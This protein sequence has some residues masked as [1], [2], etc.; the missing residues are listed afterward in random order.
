[1][2][3]APLGSH[4]LVPEKGIKMAFLGMCK[5]HQLRANF[6]SSA[7]PRRGAMGALRDPAAPRCAA[8][9]AP[10]P[11]PRCPARPDKDRITWR[12]APSRGRAAVAA[13]GAEHPGPALGVPRAGGAA[14]TRLSAG[15]P[16][17]AAAR[18][19][20]SPGDSR[21]LAA[22]G[23]GQPPSVA[24]LLTFYLTK[25]SSCTFSGPRRGRESLRGNKTR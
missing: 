17:N 20:T 24:F 3:Q 16:R 7:P 10:G 2:S 6:P 1:M 4:E 11:P 15:P 19:R 22:P 9:P 23:H 25:R 8:A 12:P 18:L 5:V 14:A 21:R 13:W